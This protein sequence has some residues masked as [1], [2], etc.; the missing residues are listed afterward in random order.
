[1]SVIHVLLSNSLGAQRAVFQIRI[2]FMQIQI[3]LLKWMWPMRIRIRIQ[4]VHWNQK[5]LQRQIKCYRYFFMKIK[6]H[7]IFIN[8]IDFNTV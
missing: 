5:A 6:S 7:I 4:V 3:Q 8:Y 2:N 1:M